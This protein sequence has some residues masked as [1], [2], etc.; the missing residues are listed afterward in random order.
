MDSMRMSA[1]KSQTASALALVKS[2]QIK[3][4]TS[5]VTGPKLSFKSTLQSSVDG[6]FK[7]TSNEVLFIYKCNEMTTNT[8]K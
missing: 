8:F 3:P 6:Y 2:P 7:K 5:S 4:V 1:D